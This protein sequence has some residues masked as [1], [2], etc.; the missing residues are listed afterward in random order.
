[1]SLLPFVNDVSLRQS[2]L[3]RFLC[4]AGAVFSDYPGDG[5]FVQHFGWGAL[6]KRPEIRILTGRRAIKAEEKVRA[7]TRALGGK[8]TLFQEAEQRGAAKRTASWNS[9]SRSPTAREA[10]SLLMRTTTM[11]RVETGAREGRVLRAAK[12]ESNAQ[13][14]GTAGEGGESLVLWLPALSGL[15]WQGK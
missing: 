11:N 13:M 3:S 15:A 10:P 5:S 4:S 6:G 7:R 9:A 12:G 14:T 2:I 1:M 8:N